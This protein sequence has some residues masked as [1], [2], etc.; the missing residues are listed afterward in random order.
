MLTWKA[1]PSRGVALYRV[2]R[3]AVSWQACVGSTSSMSLNTPL[4]ENSVTFYVAAENAAGKL[5]VLSAPATLTVSK[6]GK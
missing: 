1:S 3:E 5:S 6:G 2:F 4:T